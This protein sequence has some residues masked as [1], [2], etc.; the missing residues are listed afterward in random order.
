MN[1][2]SSFLSESFRL[3]WISCNRSL[4]FAISSVSVFFSPESEIAVLSPPGGLREK[5]AEIPR[6]S[7]PTPIKVDQILHKEL[8][9][10][11]GLSIEG[12]V[13]FVPFDTISALATGL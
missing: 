8:L 3:S 11:T 7:S 13:R 6:A 12:Q 2:S 9:A 4:F 10:E 5:P 1:S